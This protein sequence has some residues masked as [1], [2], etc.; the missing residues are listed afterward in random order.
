LISVIELPHPEQVDTGEPPQPRV[1]LGDV[2]GE[3]RNHR[4]TPLGAGDLPADV[5]ADLPIE[6]DERGIHRL[7]GALAR[8][9]D[10]PLDLRE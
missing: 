10:K 7:I 3:P 9:G 5:A 4:V 2:S 6:F 1:G 8:G